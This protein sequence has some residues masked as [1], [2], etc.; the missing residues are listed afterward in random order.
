MSRSLVPLLHKKIVI[1]KDSKVHLN[2][3]L[4]LNGSFHQPRNRTR[5]CRPPSDGDAQCRR[6]IRHATRSA[7]RTQAATPHL[8]AAGVAAAAAA[9]DT[10]PAATAVALLAAQRPGVGTLTPVVGVAMTMMMTRMTTMMGL[11]TAMT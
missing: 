10:P 11:M 1:Y 5:S 8:R 9:A 4:N 2:W 3:D 7:A 6:R